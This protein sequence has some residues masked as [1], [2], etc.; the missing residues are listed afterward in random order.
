MAESASLP[1]SI[2]TYLKERWADQQAYFERKA[3]A[4]QTLYMRTRVV[5]LV[6][7]WLKKYESSPGSAGV[8]VEV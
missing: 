8:A 3:T 6:A 7:I 1:P 2:E 4:N 5:T